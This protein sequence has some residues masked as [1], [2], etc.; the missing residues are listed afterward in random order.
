ME[1]DEIEVADAKPP[2]LIRVGGGWAKMWLPGLSAKLETAT[3]E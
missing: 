2:F 1:L 3:E